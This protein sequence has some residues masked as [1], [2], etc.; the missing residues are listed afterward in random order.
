MNEQHA[1]G[2]FTSDERMVLRKGDP[3]LM[4]EDRERRFRKGETE[5]TLFSAAG[6]RRVLPGLG[7]QESEAFGT[8][9]DSLR[10]T[11]ARL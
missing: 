8:F 6:L 7:T 11:T 10:A 9:V 5:L 1:E 4:R 3:R 2:M